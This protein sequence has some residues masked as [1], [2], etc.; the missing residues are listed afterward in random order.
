MNK[1]LQFEIPAFRLD[2]I[3]DMALLFALIAINKVVIF[4]KLSFGSISPDSSL[5]FYLAELMVSDG[6]LAIK[7]WG[8]IDSGLILPPLYPFLIGVFNHLYPGNIVA[9]AEMISSACVLIAIVPIYFSVLMLSNRIF[10]FLVTSIFQ[11]NYHYVL[12]GFSSLTEG[13]FLFTI[14]LATCLAIKFFLISKSQ[15]WHGAFFVGV[16]IALVFFTRQIGLTFFVAVTLWLGARVLLHKTFSR[17]T[18]LKHLIGFFAGFMFLVL[19]YSFLLYQQT[20]H[21]LLTQSYRQGLYHIETR[22]PVVI[23]NLQN[24]KELADGDYQTLYAERRKMMSL[25]SDSSEMLLYVTEEK[26]VVTPSSSGVMHDF[27]N[28]FQLLKNGLANVGSNLANN[29]AYLYLALGGMLTALALLSF[30][31]LFQRNPEVG[32]LRRLFLP[33]LFITYMFFASLFGS[34]IS[35]YAVVIFPI[36]LIHIAAEGYLLLKRP[37]SHRIP[38]TWVQGVVVGASCFLLVL[39][40]LYPPLSSNSLRFPYSGKLSMGEVNL[41]YISKSTPIFGVEGFGA[42]RVGGLHRTLPNDTLEKIAQ[43]AQKTGVEFLIINTDTR[44]GAFYDKTEW[45]REPPPIDSQFLKLRQQLP[46][47]DLYEIVQ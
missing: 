36:V 20:G 46:G 31:T 11:S 18:S 34:A 25:T 44:S 37:L 17:D 1:F 12:S 23:E 42:L 47:Y 32:F 8:H 6:T 39:Y 24:S 45:F 2:V 40:F 16:A 30:V 5:Y 38:K 9:V 28:I 43:Y 35:R 26:L 33:G 7:G 4:F 19:P 21:S 10:A 13:L 29:M 27:S 3:K 41:P 15:H 14:S 22:D